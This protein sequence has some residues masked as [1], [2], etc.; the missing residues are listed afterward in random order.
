MVHHPAVTREEDHGWYET[1]IDIDAHTE[2]VDIYEFDSI[3]KT[4]YYRD[5]SIIPLHGQEAVNAHCSYHHNTLNE[6]CQWGTVEYLVETK[7]I[8]VPAVTHQEW[9]SNMVTVTVSEAYDEVVVEYYRC[10]DCGLK[11]YQ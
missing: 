8:E 4:C 5:G 3:C 11:K 1:K 7:Y 2:Q 10:T 6:G 9:V